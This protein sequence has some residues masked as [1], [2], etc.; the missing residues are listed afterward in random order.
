MTGPTALHVPAALLERY[1]VAAPRYTS[2][3]TAV[4]WRGD[5]DPATY[6][7]RLATAASAPGP[8]AVYVHIPFCEALCLFCG[9]SVVITQKHDRGGAYVDQLALEF[10]AAGKTGIGR[11]A[12][13]QYHW[14][15][16]T[17]TFL[18][19]SEITRLHE[20]FSRAFT[21]A[22]DAE[23]AIEVDPRH[24][25]AGQIALLARLGF[26]RIS[27]GVQDFDQQVQEAV[28]RVQSFEQTRAVCDAARAAGIHSLNIDLIYGLPWQTPA[29]FAR[30]LE[31]VLEIRPERVALFNY[32][33]VPWIRKHQTALPESAFPSPAVKMEI[34]TQSVARFT[35]AGYDYIGLDHFALPHDELAIARRAGTLQ[36]NF[37]GYTTRRGDDLLPFGM[38][39][40]GSVGGA[41]VANPRDL[42]A[43]STRVDQQGLAVERGHVLDADDALRSAVIMALMCVGRVDIRA[44]ERAHGIAF[45]AHFATEI[46]ELAPAVADG[47]VTITPEAITATTLGQV[48]LRN[49]AVPFDRYFRLRRE[50]AAG[51]DRTFSRTV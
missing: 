28:N 32:A 12:V 19:E 24:T 33:H 46:A 20:A 5:L 38:S 15:G 35:A 22:P 3:P 4:D 31:R 10:A 41:F 9:C 40:I 21:L 26:N 30:T 37:M 39:A 43:W 45:A 7:A 29:G 51:T 42:T 2:Y 50:R 44:I 23:V 18:S 48:F 11:R 14:G 47:L 6:A 27:L 13:T 8:L 1:A 16:G 17:P 34:F 49:I 25:T 36:R